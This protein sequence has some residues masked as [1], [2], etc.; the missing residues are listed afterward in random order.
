MINCVYL[1]DSVIAEWIC[2]QHK[3]DGKK[4]HTKQHGIN[5]H[6]YL[7]WLQIRQQNICTIS[8]E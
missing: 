5:K 1:I 2:Q 7:F 4:S 6:T 8:P 3:A